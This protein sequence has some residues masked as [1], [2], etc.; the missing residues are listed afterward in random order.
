MTQ[1]TAKEKTKRQRPPAASNEWVGPEL[2]RLSALPDAAR[3]ALWDVVGPL[4]NARPGAAVDARIER[5]ARVHGA[6]PAEV[7]RA[8]R[9]IR[10]LTRSAA[11][12]DL[13]AEAFAAEVEALG[14]GPVASEI[15]LAGY[16]AGKAVI[17]REAARALLAEHG[18]VVEGV[19][20]RVDVVTGVK[21]NERMR[22]P[23]GLLTLKYR[24]GEARRKLTVQLLPDSIKELQKLCE[25][26]A[27]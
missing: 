16:E 22:L 23:V 20:W 9:V 24:D 12:R 17:R 13:E 11:N 1:P 6:A 14:A 7:A 5:F 21:G 15:L 10:H 4:L 25:R 18:S 26:M 8:V 2:A 3:A 19:E 27:R